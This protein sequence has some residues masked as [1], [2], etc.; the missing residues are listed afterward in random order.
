MKK[1]LILTAI[2]LTSLLANARQAEPEYIIKA[3]EIHK[4]LAPVIYSLQEQAGQ[5]GQQVNKRLLKT[6]KQIIDNSKMNIKLKRI[7][8]NGISDITVTELFYHTGYIKDNLPKEIKEE[9]NAATLQALAEY[10]L[11]DDT[12]IN[13]FE[14]LLAI[15]IQP[16]EAFNLTKDYCKVNLNE[17]DNTITYTHF[18]KL[19]IGYSETKMSVSL[20]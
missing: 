20:P 6:C 17:T 11:K 4:N 7:N 15:G 18:E 3:R 14:A 16:L 10:I 12:E 5:A 9:Q 8:G 19:P 2:F 1:T 13:D